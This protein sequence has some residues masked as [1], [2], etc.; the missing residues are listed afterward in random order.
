MKK[1]LEIFREAANEEIVD[2]DVHVV[3][4]KCV[5]NRIRVRGKD[6]KNTAAREAPG[7]GPHQGDSWRLDCLFP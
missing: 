7:N 1:R 2:D 3:E 4:V 6:I 5:V